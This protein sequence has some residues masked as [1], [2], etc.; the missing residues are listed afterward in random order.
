MKKRKVKFV[1][2]LL[3]VFVLGFTGIFSLSA[4]AATKPVFYKTPSQAAK[5]GLTFS[6]TETIS[7]TELRNISKY[8]DNKATNES[9]TAGIATS[10]LVVPLKPIVSIPVGNAVAIIMSYR[11]TTGKL[12]NETLLNSN[13]N[14]KFT[15]K[16]TY[17]YYRKGSSDG[18]YTLQN[19]QIKKK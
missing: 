3:L 4:E 8:F 12:V 10:L 5:I 14:A 1:V 13:T 9:I 19:I 17:K 15:V 7:Y 11:N 18:M 2:S 16:M 6:T